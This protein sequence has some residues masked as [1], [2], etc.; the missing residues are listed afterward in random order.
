MVEKSI[1]LVYFVGLNFDLPLKK[2]DL[3][4]N[5]DKYWNNSTGEADEA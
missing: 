2:S 5:F 3:I 1:S 4:I